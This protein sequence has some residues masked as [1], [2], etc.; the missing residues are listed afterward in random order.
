MGLLLNQGCVRCLL[1]LSH[2]LARFALAFRTFVL[3]N[4]TK[5]FSDV[6]RRAIFSFPVT[7]RTKVGIF[8]ED[9]YFHPRI[10][11]DRLCEDR[12]LQE[13]KGFNLS[14]TTIMSATSTRRV[15]S[16]SNTTF[17]SNPQYK[18]IQQGLSTQ[19][20]YI[21]YCFANNTAKIFIWWW[22]ATTTEPTSQRSTL[23]WND[24]LC[25]H[26]KV[27][28]LKRLFTAIPQ[29]RIRTSSGQA[30]CGHRI[31]PTWKRL[32]RLPLI[33]NFSI[34]VSHILSWCNAGSTCP[35][36]RDKDHLLLKPVI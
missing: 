17:N 34:G 21:S 12:T 4:I 16:H 29:E 9:S 33:R 30:W 27:T 14:N 10:G 23:P 2:F 15:L 22:V 13:C 32:A 31:W 5:N 19:S 28:V 36:K 11:K 1:T 35:W 7:K 26:C 18:N 24:H 20:Q 6:W 8:L 3:F 25:K